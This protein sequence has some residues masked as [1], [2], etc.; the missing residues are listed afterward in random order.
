M[1]SDVLQDLKHLSSSLDC[2]LLG[3]S[4]DSVDIDL[5]L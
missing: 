3:S 5:D 4:V 1:I 2:I